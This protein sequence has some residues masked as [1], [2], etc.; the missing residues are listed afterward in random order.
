MTLKRIGG[1]DAVLGLLGAPRED[2]RRTLRPVE[3]TISARNPPTEHRAFAVGDRV[4]T[5]RNDPHTGAVNGK[6]GTLTVIAADGLTIKSD[7]GN[8]VQIPVRYVRDGHLD[9]G[10]ATTAHRAQGA[11]VD[12]TFVLGSDELYRE[13]GYAALSRHRE[14]SRSYVTAAPAFL[15]TP[16]EPLTTDDDVIRRVARILDDSRAQRPA[17]PDTRMA[18]PGELR[19]ARDPLAPLGRERPI[20]ASRSRGR[21]LGLEL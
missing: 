1:N 19:R 12:R 10:Y 20:P 8:H 11:T 4:V 9:H 6:A 5:T 13:W 21:D 16:P 17:L 18:Q 15:N 3:E 7:N 14:A 2:E